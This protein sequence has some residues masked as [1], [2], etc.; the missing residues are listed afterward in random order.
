MQMKNVMRA[1]LYPRVSTEEQAKF[2]LSIHDQ[3]NDLERY[4]KEHGMKIVGVFAD[5]GFSARKKIEK[6]PAMMA[7]LDAVRRDEVDIVLVTKLD[8]WFR[9]IGEY[10]KVQEILEAHNVSWKTIYEDYETTTASGRLKINIMLAVAQ[11]EADRTSERIKKINEGKR[12]RREALTGDKPFGYA[13]VNRKFVKD[14]KTEAAV[15]AFFHKYMACGSMSATLDYIREEYG[16]AIPYQTA[17]KMTLNSAYYGTYYDTEGMTPPYITKEQYDMIQAMRPK[18]VKRT[19]ENRTYVFSGLIRCGDCGGRIGGKV[20]QD[21]KTYHYNCSNH[22][23]RRKPCENNRSISERKLEKYLLDNIEANLESY[24]MEYARLQEKTEIKDYRPE[25]NALR[26][27]LSRLKDLYLNEMLTMEEYKKDYTAITEK[28][29]ELEIKQQPPRPSN[30]PQ[31]EKLLSDNW[32]DMYGILT[33]I[34]KREFWR[35]ILQ[36]IRWFPDRHIEFDFN[37]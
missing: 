14:P 29:Q 11:D 10:Y 9:N 6:R 37:F 30:L 32:R 19:D 2:G 1:A 24:K 13:I 26:G 16:I 34:Q 15:D 4:A 28:I 21:Q 17:R 8:R 7:L 25:I 3:Q 5:A 20:N 18:R 22:F 23:C 31:I 27:R 35:I 33:P 36:E 12:A